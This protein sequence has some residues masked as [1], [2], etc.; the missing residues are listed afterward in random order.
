MLR[1]CALSCGCRQGEVV[2][3]PNCKDR[4]NSGSCASWA[5]QGECEANPS[6]MKMRCAASCG[7]CDMLD[8]NK[9]CPKLEGRAEAVPPNTMT[10][11]FER[12]VRD[13]A[14]LEP[15]VLSTDPWI[16]SFDRFL[17]AEE[18][19]S[20][21]KQGEGR[22]VRSTA[23][24]GR[25]DDEFVP[26][27]SEIRTSWTTW[28]DSKECLADPVMRRVTERVSNVT[29]VPSANF[30]FLQ[31]LRYMPCGHAGA[32]DCQFY[33]RHHDTIPELATMQ[34]GPRVY[35]FF[36]Y[37]SDVEEG[38]G[39]QFDGGI[40]VYPKAGRAL[41]WPATLEDRPF[42][43]DDRTHHEALPVLKGTKYAGNFWLHQ[44]DYVTAHTNG[45]TT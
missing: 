30:E 17:D 8:Y 16:L 32:S 40:T 1:A 42:V 20:V 34:P 38:G 43:S 12:A 33:K 39:T 28:C 36:L 37:L 9:R 5:A 18:A 21:L 3:P 29:R 14:E 11:T 45:C 22:F 44:Y 23:S 25:K 6:F 35:T 7:T 24:G 2:P 4:D 41:L 26:I 27:T 19:E 10:E 31:L 15:K 13:F